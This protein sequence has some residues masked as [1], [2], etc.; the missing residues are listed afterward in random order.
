MSNNFDCR[1][2]LGRSYIFD[3]ILLQS[4]KYYGRLIYLPSSR[5]LHKVFMEDRELHES[6]ANSWFSFIEKYS[7]NIICP[8]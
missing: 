8:T 5:L 7:S 6:R 2:E 4:L 1:W 3:N